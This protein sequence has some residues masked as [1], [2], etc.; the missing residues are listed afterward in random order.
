MNHRAWCPSSSAV[1]AV[2][3]GTAGVRWI[4][5]GQGPARRLGESER[6]EL[7]RGDR[8]ELTFARAEKVALIVAHPLSKIRADDADAKRGVLAGFWS[9]ADPAALRTYHRSAERGARAREVAQPR[10]GQQL[11]YDIRI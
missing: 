1:G 3:L 6:L 9:C 10:T 8:V 11:S 5:S 4:R 7:R 2:A